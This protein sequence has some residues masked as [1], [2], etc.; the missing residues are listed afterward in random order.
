MCTSPLLLIR[1]GSVI[2]MRKKYAQRGFS[3]SNFE[4][5]VVAHRKTPRRQGKKQK[6]YGPQDINFRQ[7]EASQNRARITTNKCCAGECFD[8]LLL[9]LML[10]D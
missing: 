2:N 6:Q 8:I 9:L 4:M 1:D 5:A 7:L 3:G 10:L